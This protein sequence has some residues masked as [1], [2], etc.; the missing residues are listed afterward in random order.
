GDGTFTALSFTDGRFLDE[1][2]QV[3]R[4]TPMDWG[5]SAQF[6]DLNGDGLPDLY[7]C[8]DLFTPDRFWINQG[9]GRFRAAP[10]LALR[11]TSLASMS[12]DVADVNRDGY[13]DF[14]VTDMFSWDRKL[15]MTQF[16][17]VPPPVWDQAAIGERL[18]FNHNTLLLNRGDTTFA[19]IA[20]YGGV[21]AS[22]LSW[23]GIFLDVG[24]DGYADLLVPVGQQ[25]NLAPGDF[26]TRIQQE[27]RTHGK[28]T[29]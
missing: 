5:L 13:Y 8:N 11:H 22:D 18:Q 17:H 6:H 3:L 21:A 23:G 19:E 25:R 2:G 9:G 16:A 7:V 20:F 24:L 15:R 28:V 12:V 4:E 10:R 27:Q 26:A 1:D 29:L 14:F